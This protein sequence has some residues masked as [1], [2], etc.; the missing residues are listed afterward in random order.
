[1]SSS[2]TMPARF[3]ISDAV[4]VDLV[5]D[6]QFYV[7]ELPDALA[8]ATSATLATSASFSTVGSCGSSVSTTSSVSSASG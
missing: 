3:G 2:E 8:A 5:V 7:E 1:M 6:E 4:S